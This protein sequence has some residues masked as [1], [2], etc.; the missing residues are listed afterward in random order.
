MSNIIPKNTNYTVEQV[1]A[2][3][4]DHAMAGN[5]LI[6]AS[7]GSGKTRVLVERVIHLLL[8]GDN[9]VRLDHLVIV[10]FTEL[11]AREMKERIEQAL[12]EHYNAEEAGSAK[13]RFIQEQLL[14]LPNANIQTIDAFCRQVVQRYYYLIGLDPNFRL[15]TD[16][17]ALALLQEQVWQELVSDILSDEQSPL[18]AD[19]ESV[20]LNFSD[21]SPTKEETVAGIVSALYHKSRA[22]PHP[23]QWLNDLVRRYPTT[24]TYGESALFNDLIRPRLQQALDADLEPY[25]QVVHDFRDDAQRLQ[26]KFNNKYQ[27]IAEALAIYERLVAALANPHV[28][29]QQLYQDFSRDSLP[30]FSKPRHITEPKTEVDEASNALGDVIGALNA[31]FEA[32]YYKKGRTLD[33]YLGFSDPTQ[34]EMLRQ[35]QTVAAALVHLT[36]AFTQR[37][38]AAMASQQVIDFAGIELAALAILETKNAAGHYEARDYYQQTMAEILIDEYQDVNALQEA[39]MVAISREASPQQTANRF[40]VGDVKQSIY[41]FRFSDPTLFQVKYAHYAP[42]VTGQQTTDPAKIVLKENFRSRQ[43]VLYFVNSIFDRLMDQHVGGVDYRQEARLVAGNREYAPDARYAPELYLVATEPKEDQEA[44]DKDILQAQVVAA[45]IQSLLAQKFEI[46]ERNQKRLRP[47]TYR[48]IAILSNTRSHYLAV[49]KVFSAQEIPLEQDKR[50]NFFK[51]TEIMTMVAILNLIDNPKQDIPLATLLRSPLIHMS[52]PE[53]A[54]IRTQYKKGHYFEAVAHYRA[55]GQDPK[56]LAKLTQLATWLETWRDENQTASL[57]TLIWRIY[58]DTG[59]LDYVGG[60]TNG[61]QRQANLFALLQQAEAFERQMGRGLFQFVRYIEETER[62]QQDL[63]T[64]QTLDPN[65]DAVQLL[66][67]HGSKGLEFPVVFYFNAQ[68]AF[69][70]QDLNAGWVVSDHY[71]L[72]VK[73]IDYKN[74]YSFTNPLLTLA[75]ADEQEAMLA[76]E[77]RKLYVAFTRAE[78]KLIIVG[79]VKQPEQM[80]EAIAQTNQKRTTL[81]SDSE[82]LKRTETPL[83]WV[84]LA[85]APAWQGQLAKL[86]AKEAIQATYGRGDQQGT[87]KMQVV[88]PEQLDLFAPKV[89]PQ[90]TAATPQGASDSVQVITSPLS[91]TY[92]YQAATTTASNQSV[93]EW[94]RRLYQ[95][96]DERVAPWQTEAQ[97]QRRA[98]ERNYRE[99]DFPTPEF[100]NATPHVRSARERG[101]GT[102]LLMQK[103]PL[104]SPPQADDFRTLAQSLVETGELEPGQVDETTFAHLAEFFDPQAA[105][106]RPFDLSQRLWRNYQRLHREQPFAY[107]KPTNTIANQ[108][109]A[110]Q[111]DDPVLIRGIIDGFFQD[112]AGQWWM[113]D[114][115]TDHLQGLSMAQARE[116]LLNRYR[117]QLALY[118]EALSSILGQA[119]D[120]IV[121]VSLDTL[122]SFEYERQEFAL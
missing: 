59:Y 65:S 62:H 104:A 69:N 105:A 5:L 102:H 122:W 100:L 36:Q 99:D 121:I 50:E 3:Y 21:G 113:F 103:I 47:I 76:E 2:I 67:V 74:L 75:K 7:A 54:V 114:Y 72:G 90:P 34:T 46:Y 73:N 96:E 112:E 25:R 38:Q 18:Y 117:T 22:H 32:K 115:K 48:D 98:Q 8:D 39:I 116:V 77:M 78:Q 68:K 19:Y 87:F 85:L 58:Q 56:I 40:M 29:Y 49:E 101:I 71:G 93:S 94:K 1:Q 33:Q 95:A 63:A 13:A 88:D 14:L 16:E 92:P 15:L 89:A 44:E 64:P 106:A 83:S 109:T 6:S 10:T 17:T 23:D 43:E 81:I 4:T 61:A 111:T 110:S 120:H 55:E 24:E 26:G 79:G 37:M 86:T 60:Q 51:R 31:D 41:R 27:R 107:Q 53:M 119:V 108:I 28:Q 30:K 70:L 91:F 57:A 118:D 35:A 11:A 80:L 52:E 82:R 20:A 9:P 66:S 84:L 42:F 12:R 45:R 97:F